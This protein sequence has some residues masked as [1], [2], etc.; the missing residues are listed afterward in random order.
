MPKA[1]LIKHLRGKYGIKNPKNI[2]KHLKD[3]ENDRCIDKIDPLRD[4][5]ENK[6][7]ITTREHLKNIKYR[8][9]DNDCFKRIKLNRY[10]RSLNIILKQLGYNVDSPNASRFRVQL[11]FSDFFFDMYLEKDILSSKY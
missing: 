4:G 3:L 7:N 6:W 8:S 5:F 10:E 9:K 1:D 11:F 2:K